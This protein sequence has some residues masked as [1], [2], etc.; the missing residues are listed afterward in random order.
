MEMLVFGLIVSSFGKLL[1]ILMV[2]WDYRGD[3]YSWIL[4]PFVLTSNAEA[5]S[6]AVFDL[7][8]LFNPYSCV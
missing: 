1:H 6:G 4:N 5:I 2:I 3:E 7:C 8:A